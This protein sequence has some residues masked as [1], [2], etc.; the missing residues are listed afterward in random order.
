MKQKNPQSQLSSASGSDAV[1]KILLIS[2]TEGACVMVAELA[3]SK[4][5]TPF[6]GSSMYVWASTLSVTLGALTLGYY[7]GGTLTRSAERDR[8]RLLFSLLVAA[9]LLVLVM[10]FISKAVCGVLVEYTFFSGMIISQLIF[11]FPPIFFMGSVSPVIIDILAKDQNSGF[12][13][14]RVYAISTLGG[15]LAT[16]LAGFWFIPAFG[17]SIPCIV[18][19]L[20]LLAISIICLKPGLI[21]GSA[22]VLTALILVSAG[23]VGMKPKGEGMYKV[24]YHL[25]Q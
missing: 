13:A 24:Q 10:P 6:F 1:K 11:L 16:L 4:M 21:K 20:L 22:S 23:L 19:G 14:G 12:A 3:G 25:L 2:F 8:P 18:A 5:L 17:I 7:W 15:I 9:S